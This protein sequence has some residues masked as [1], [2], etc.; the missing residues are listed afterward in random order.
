MLSQLSRRA[1]EGH[2]RHAV[3]RKTCLLQC[4]WL[5]VTEKPTQTGLHSK[6]MYS[7]LQLEAQSG[8]RPQAPPVH[9][10]PEPW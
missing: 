5:Q 9:L 8:G 7:L 2:F 1:E 6:K 4:F 3:T 10:P